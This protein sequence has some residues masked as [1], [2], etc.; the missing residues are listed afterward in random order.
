MF[1]FFHS[2][3]LKVKVVARQHLTE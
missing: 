1:S 2:S 3:K